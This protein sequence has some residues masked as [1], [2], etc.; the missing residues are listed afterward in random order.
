MEPLAQRHILFIVSAAAIRQTSG[1]MLPFSS[2]V[3]VWE[4]SE[5]CQFTVLASMSILFLLTCLSSLYSLHLFAFFF[6]FLYFVVY[7]FINPKKFQQ[8]LG[9]TYMS[10]IKSTCLPQR[11][12]QHL[13]Q[14][15]YTT[16]YN[17]SR[18]TEIVPTQTCIW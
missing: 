9:L 1:R 7:F 13:Y 18:L 10:R 8:N 14:S 4:R 3:Y 11:G 17:P 12:Q 16:Y 6:S 15:I 5:S 2:H